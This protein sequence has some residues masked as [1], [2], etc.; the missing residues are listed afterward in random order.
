[1]FE[2]GTVVMGAGYHSHPRAATIH[3]VLLRPQKA[4]PAVRLRVRDGQPALPPAGPGGWTASIRQPL[5]S[6]ASLPS[7]SATA[8]ASFPAF[9]HGNRQCIGSA[10][11]LCCL[12]RVSPSRPLLKNAWP[13]S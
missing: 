10:F 12:Q 7:I 4:R 3:L 6:P 9:C 13:S 2:M 11:P 1:M 5:Q 8:S